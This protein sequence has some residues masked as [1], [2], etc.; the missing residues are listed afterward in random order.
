MMKKFLKEQIEKIDGTILDVKLFV[1]L[2]TVLSIA[3]YLAMA[4]IVYDLN[5]AHWEPVDRFGFIFFELFA[6]G[7]AL[8]VSSVSGSTKK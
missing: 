2:A 1:F 6:I 3:T 7:T 8:L 5:P 4:F